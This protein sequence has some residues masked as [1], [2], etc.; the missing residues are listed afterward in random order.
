MNNRNLALKIFEHYRTV[1][2]QLRHYYGIVAIYGLTVLTEDLAENAPEKSLL[3]QI[4]ATFPDQIDH[5]NYNFPSYRIGGFARARAFW[6][7][8]DHREDLIRNYAEELMTARR[9][10][11][12]LLCTPKEGMEHQV[13]V[14]C[15]LATG[16]Y[17]LFAGLALNERK[18]ID[19]AVK[20]AILTYDLFMDSG[21]GLLHQ[22][23]GLCKGYSIAKISEDHWGRGNGWAIFPLS[24]MI[25]YLPKEHP[26]YTRLLRYYKNHVDALVPYQSENG[27]WRQEITLEKLDDLESYEETSG[28]GLILYAIA[29]GIR[30]GVLDREKYLPV[31]ERGVQ[32][33]KKL[34]VN[35]N[36]GIE[37]SC[38]ACR[39]PGDATIRAYLSHKAPYTDEP[40]G[41]GPVIM[42]LV[43]ADSCGA[44]C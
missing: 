28:T 21:C 19:E 24:E 26:E 8:T 11:V 12:G 34:S 5:P 16:T 14:D 6:N 22:G 43:A 36:F 35:K 7:G 29:Q 30:V 39:C 41:A 20:Q 31:V 27:F 1:N 44:E 10:Q 17:L 3:R 40:H 13:W 9:N 38:P 32:G 4:L 42:A 15:L 37:N 18:Y 25:A 33:L 23:Q 2:P